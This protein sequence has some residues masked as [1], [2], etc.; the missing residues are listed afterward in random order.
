P[1]PRAA[2]ARALMLVLVRHGETLDNRSGRLLGRS[3]PPLT[4]LGRVQARSLA[5]TLTGESPATVLSSPLLRAVQTATLIADACA[6]GVAVDKRLVEIDY[7]AWERR[8]L[9]EI[10]T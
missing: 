2:T 9:R 5:A 10:P 4:P 3:D 7:G 6:V 8:P 1:H